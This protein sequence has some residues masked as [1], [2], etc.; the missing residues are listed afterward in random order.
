MK[1]AAYFLLIFIII[2]GIA[3]MF[4]EG[5]IQETIKS[6][7]SIAGWI[8]GGAFGSLIIYMF[9]KGAIILWPILETTFG[10]SRAEEYGLII[11]SLFFMVCCLR[12][13]LIDSSA[14]LGAA[15]LLSSLGTAGLFWIWRRVR[16]IYI[17]LTDGDEAFHMPNTEYF[18]ILS[19]SLAASVYLTSMEQGMFTREYIGFAAIVIFLL[20]IASGVIFYWFYYTIKSA[21]RG[22]KYRLKEYIFTE[23]DLVVYGPLRT[24]TIPCSSIRSIKKIEA[25]TGLT[26]IPTAISRPKK[27]ELLVVESKDRKSPVALTWPG[28]KKEEKFKSEAR[29]RGAV[30]IE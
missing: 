7:E 30:F 29:E 19:F 14:G 2:T 20:F 9:L 15:V 1:K 18:L 21:A 6:P 10:I 22:K 12:D 17:R 27:A 4:D 26:A 8:V 16:N 13:G 25:Y 5:W 11:S 24:V 3:A 23:R 28:E